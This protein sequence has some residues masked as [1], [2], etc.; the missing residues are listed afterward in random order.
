MKGKVTV[1]T[2]IGNELSYDLFVGNNANITVKVTRGG[3]V[4]EVDI[5][6]RQI[7]NNWKIVGID[8]F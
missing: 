6:L 4:Q 1:Y 5:Q 2:I 8:H 7:G 3:E